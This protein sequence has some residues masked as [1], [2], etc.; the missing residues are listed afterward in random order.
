MFHCESLNT[1]DISFIAGLRGQK[2]KGKKPTI[3][4]LYDPTAI[5]STKKHISLSCKCSY[6]PIRKSTLYCV[7]YVS[8]YQ[9]DEWYRGVS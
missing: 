5:E 6:V 2:K 1:T 4:N 9:N 8:E 3:Q 7:K